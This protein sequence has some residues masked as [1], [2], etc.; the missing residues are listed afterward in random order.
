MF[1]KT[2]VFQDIDAA[3]EFNRKL[4][5]IDCNMDLYPLYKRRHVIDAKSI[6]GIFTLDLSKPVV[7]KAYTE[8]PKVIREI[9]EITHDI[10]YK[11]SEISQP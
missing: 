11:G 5:N 7:L 6:M 8:D 1:E 4:A 2:I 10:S 9:N 3:K